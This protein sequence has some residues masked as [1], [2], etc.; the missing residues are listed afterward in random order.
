MRRLFLGLGLLF[1]GLGFLGVVLPVLPTTPFL[2]LAVACFAR[3]S[4]RLERWFLRLISATVFASFPL[5]VTEIGY[6]RNGSGFQGLLSHPQF[7]GAFLGVA[8]S[9]L[10]AI[11]F[12]ERR[13]TVFLLIT[14]AIAFI[15]LVASEARVG[16]AT[17]LGTVVFVSIFFAPAGAQRRR[18]WNTTRT[19]ASTS[20]AGCRWSSNTASGNTLPG[21]RARLP[22]SLLLRL[23]GS[24]ALPEGP[25][26]A[27]P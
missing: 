16:V 10:F 18:A 25:I 15:S 3:S 11:A 12:L 20:A 19:P 17:L 1:A 4:T 21:G 27:L 8:L 14:M 7:Y 2:I 22:P 5:I 26:R 24:L 9:W 6:F 23:G 13:R